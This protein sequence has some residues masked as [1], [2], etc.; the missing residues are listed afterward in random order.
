[1]GKNYK[2]Y[3]CQYCDRQ[4]WIAKRQQHESDCYLNPTNV[5][6]CECGDPIKNWKYSVT[7]S[8]SCANKKFRSGENNGNWKQDTYV[9]TCFLY[10]KKECIICGEQNIVEVH[11]FDENKK[12]NSPTNLVPL[13]PTHHQ[14]WHSRFKYLVEQKVIDY[15]NDFCYK[16]N[17]KINLSVAQPG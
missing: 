8:Y 10:H 16:Y 15:M 13:C 4:I 9:T 2:Q 11:H 12:N 14:Y 3:N 5:R 17:N 6:Y 7:C 1:M